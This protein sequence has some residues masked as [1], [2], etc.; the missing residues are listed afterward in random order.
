MIPE[1]WPF[2]VQLP[3]SCQ[4]E[5]EIRSQPSSETI[6]ILD[7][8]VTEILNFC[9]VFFLGYAVY[10]CILNYTLY[11]LLTDPQITENLL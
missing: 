11:P 7:W 8:M 1:Q 3:S 10:I 4:I 2:D 6:M 5:L 9:L